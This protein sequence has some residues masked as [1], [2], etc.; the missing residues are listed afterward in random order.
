MTNQ[1]KHDRK[2]LEAL[3]CPL[4]QSVLEYNEENQELISKSLYLAVE[5]PKNLIARGGMHIGSYLGG[6][7][8]LKGLGLVHAISHMV[9]AEYNTHHG[10][11]NAIILPAVM[12]Y[13]LP[14]LEEKVK[15]LTERV[16]RLENRLKAAESSEEK[17]LAEK[18]QAIKNDTEQDKS[19]HDNA[20]DDPLIL[21]HIV[22]M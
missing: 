3:V 14:G 9:G 10:L 18:N 13:N 22:Q 19:S 8:F 6:I 20:I 15:S 1:L 11:T 5:E 21:S 12:K 16:K 4:T 2:M 7:A 17:V